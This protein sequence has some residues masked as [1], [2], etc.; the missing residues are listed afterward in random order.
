MRVWWLSH[1]PVDLGYLRISQ[2]FRPILFPGIFWGCYG[3]SPHFGWSPPPWDP[4]FRMCPTTRTMLEVRPWSS[5][6]DDAFGLPPWLWKPPYR[7]YPCDWGRLQKF[8]KP[9]HLGIRL[10]CNLP[11]P[12]LEIGGIKAPTQI[13]DAS[14]PLQGQPTELFF[15]FQCY[16][17]PRN[18]GHANGWTI[19]LYLKR[20]CSH[21]LNETIPGYLQHPPNIIKHC[22]LWFRADFIDKN[23]CL[24]LPILCHWEEDG[25][26]SSN[27]RLGPWLIK[28]RTPWITPPTIYRSTKCKL[29]RIYCA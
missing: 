29:F 23:N 7:E 1:Y 19:C 13:S 17:C 14:R 27:N 26:N 18:A 4:A 9:P 20:P 28:G 22:W 6:M 2:H 15:C 11:L 3:L 8:G 5:M 21:S 10:F 16:L 25:S 12:R 24:L